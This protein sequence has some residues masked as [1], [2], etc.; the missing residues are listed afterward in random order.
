M[1]EDEDRAGPWWAK[2]FSESQPPVPILLPGRWRLKS[3]D[4]WVVLEQGDRET[5]V[6]GIRAIELRRPTPWW[7]R[8]WRR[9]ILPSDKRVTHAKECRGPR[10]PGGEVKP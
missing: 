9:V 2:V 7:R 1:K 4:R 8:W 3:R 10:G 5:Y 6:L